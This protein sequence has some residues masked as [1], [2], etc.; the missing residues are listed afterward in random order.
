LDTHV[1]LTPGTRTIN[2]ALVALRAELE[3]RSGQRIIDVTFVGGDVTT[4]V[5][6][7]DVVARDLLVRILDDASAGSALGPNLVWT[8]NWSD[9]PEEFRGWVL[10]LSRVWSLEDLDGRFPASGPDAAVVR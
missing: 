6:G 10:N 1:T 7:E 8:L 5:A 4:S 2:E 9:G 3:A